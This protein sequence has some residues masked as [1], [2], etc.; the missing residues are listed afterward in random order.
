MCHDKLVQIH[1]RF[2]TL[3]CGSHFCQLATRKKSFT[4]AN[5]SQAKLYMRPL[6]SNFNKLKKTVAQ[7]K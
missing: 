6:K 1:E 4:L 3:V 5:M 7:V 2:D